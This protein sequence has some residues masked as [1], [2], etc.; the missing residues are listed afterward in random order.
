MVVVV[1]VKVFEVPVA[2]T[3]YGP[4]VAG[5]AYVYEVPAPPVAVKSMAVPG[6]M[7]Y[8]EG[9][10]EGLRDIRFTVTCAVPLQPALSAVTV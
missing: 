1:C 2:I 6:Q 4:G 3:L 7:E 8:D 10:S 5:P 9:I